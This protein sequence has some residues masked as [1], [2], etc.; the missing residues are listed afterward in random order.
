MTKHP[1]PLKDKVLLQLVSLAGSLPFGG[2]TF[3]FML[4]RNFQYTQH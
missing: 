4:G 3:I 2:E 1:C